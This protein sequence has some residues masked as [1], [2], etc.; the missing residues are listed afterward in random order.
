MPHRLS[1]AAPVLAGQA[2]AAHPP[3]TYP[4][5]AQPA[6]ASARRYMLLSRPS[7]R[8]RVA[9]LDDRPAVAVGLS[10]YLGEHGDFEV[11]LTETNAVALAHQLKRHPC[12]AAVIDFFMPAQSWDGVDFIRR[13]RR[14]CPDMA[15]I[16]ISAGKA[17]ETEYAAFRAGANGFLPKGAPLSLLAELIRT[18]VVSRRAF[19][20]ART[21]QLRATIPDPPDS[22]LTNAEREILRQIAQGFS[23]TQISGRLLRSKKTVS[24]HKRRAMKKLG[25]ADDLALALYLSEKF[26]QNVYG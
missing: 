12:D 16:T 9:I 18:T 24:T 1:H 6:V 7:R 23:V 13:L 11:A 2:C 8:L 15:V 20:S 19:F 10:A 21:G 26:E 4:S 22:R 3:A 14:L 5:S 17:H 25:L